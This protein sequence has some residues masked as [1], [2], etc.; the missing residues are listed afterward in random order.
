MGGE[1]SVG[2]CV[3]FQN[4]K[5]QKKLYRRFRIRQQYS[6]PND[7]AMMEEVISRRYKSETLKNDPLPNLIIIDGGKGQLNIALRVLEK[8]KINVPI[9]SIAKKKEEI[10]AEWSEEPLEIEKDSG[11][12]HLIQYVRDEAHRF[13]INYHKT[14]RLRSVKDSE[15]EKIKGIGKAKVS[16]LF[17]KYKNLEEISKASKEEIM[18]SIGVNEDAAQQILFISQKILKKHSFDD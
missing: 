12:Q 9:V 1:Y 5:P 14:L 4:G 11:A 15:F 6:E 10:Y 8:L 13:A 7:Y 3:V 16:K 18:K 17:Q 2:S